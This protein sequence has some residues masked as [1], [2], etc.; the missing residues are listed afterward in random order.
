MAV[1]TGGGSGQG[2]ATARRFVDEGAFVYITGRRQTELDKA[3]SLIGRNV[4]AVQADVSK[5]ADLD[6][7]YA[8]I[9]S[10]KNKIDVIFAAAGIVEVQPLAQ[11]TEESFDKQFAV[12]TKATIRRS[13]SCSTLPRLTS[14]GF[15]PGVPLRKGVRSGPSTSGQHRL[16]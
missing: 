10:E 9:A 5:L 14:M 1:I 6:Q 13:R 15:W 4:V 2:L 3:K 8:R 11:M 12:N 16:T 7:F